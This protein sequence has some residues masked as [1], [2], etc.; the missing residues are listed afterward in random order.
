[1]ESA[2]F[3][4]GSNISVSIL[5]Q[6]HRN[7]QNSPPPSVQK[8]GILQHILPVICRR[9]QCLPAPLQEQ[10]CGPN[11]VHS[12]GTPAHQKCS[13]DL[14]YGTVATGTYS[15]AKPHPGVFL[16]LLQHTPPDSPMG[17]RK[18]LPI[19]QYSAFPFSAPGL[20]ILWRIKSP[21]MY[22]LAHVTAGTNTVCTKQHIVFLMRCKTLSAQISVFSWP[23]QTSRHSRKPPLLFPLLH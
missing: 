22:C 10:I 14:L 11:H 17:G 3:D 7:C 9:W 19:Q 16:H 1:M 6:A 18:I 2:A 8:A 15:L 23:V 5:P 21:P 20:I 4:T 13:L 12:P